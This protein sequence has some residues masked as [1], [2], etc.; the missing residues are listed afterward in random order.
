MAEGLF[1]LDP[2]GEYGSRGGI[3]V[4]HEYATEGAVPRGVL[5]VGQDVTG[6]MR[7]QV[8]LFEGRVDPGDRAVLV[9]YP[10]FLHGAVDIIEEERRRRASR[11]PDK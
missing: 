9:S 5:V 10:E 11:P 8:R 7:E 4:P 3:V 6:W 2:G 1:L